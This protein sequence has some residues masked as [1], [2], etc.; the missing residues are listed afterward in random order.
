M[1]QTTN[2]ARLGWLHGVNPCV[3]KK[4]TPLPWILGKLFARPATRLLFCVLLWAGL[5]G[6]FRLTTFNEYE[7]R[8][9]GDAAYFTEMTQAFYLGEPCELRLPAMHSRRILGPWLAAKVCSVMDRVEGSKATKPFHYGYYAEDYFQ[10]WVAEDSLTYGRILNAWKALN[11]AAFLAILLSLFGLVEHL[12]MKRLFVAEARGDAVCAAEIL[13]SNDRT[14]AIPWIGIWLT[15]ILCCC[16]VLGRLYFVW[17]IMNDLIGIS[18]GLLSLLCAMKRRILV[19]GLLFGAGMLARE[20]LA[21]IYPCFVWIFFHREHTP[22]GG[23]PRLSLLLHSLFSF[24]PYALL[25]V[26][27]LFNNIGPLGDWSSG[28]Q[29]TVPGAAHDYLGL[30]LYHL[31]RPFVADHGL[32]RQVV[33]YWQVLGPLLL[34]MLRFYPWDRIREDALLWSGLGVAVASSF[35]VDRYVVYAIFP[36]LLLARHTLDGRVSPLLAAIV[37]VCYLEAVR[38]FTQTGSG[39]GLQVEFMRPALLSSA[40]LLGACALLA[41]FVRPVLKPV[42]PQ[43]LERYLDQKRQATVK[44]VS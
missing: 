30:A 25:C 13:K 23:T 1:Q 2:P 32:L 37:S 39:V 12:Q 18:L 24:G 15:L 33:V 27:P 43:F 4:A 29:Q 11:A 7:K 21:L 10:K 31:R 6:I 17:P 22:G 44:T 41:M 3:P 8:P 28:I 14:F 42:L 35:Y 20:N 40:A 19:S 34:L 36:L 38:F 16:P 5:L 26:F 9:I